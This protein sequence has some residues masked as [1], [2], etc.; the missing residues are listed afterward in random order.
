M[1]GISPSTRQGIK[2]DPSLQHD[3][4]ISAAIPPGATQFLLGGSLVDQQSSLGW[5]WLDGSEVIDSVVQWITDFPKVGRSQNRKI[6]KV[7]KWQLHLQSW[8]SQSIP[9]QTGW[10]MCQIVIGWHWGEL[11]K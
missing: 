10:T 9:D 3:L 8:C 4:F 1:A 7:Q 5:R 6:G 11:P 2:P